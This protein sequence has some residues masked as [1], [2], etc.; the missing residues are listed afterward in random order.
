MY[1]IYSL[2]IQTFTKTL[3]Q[4][5]YISVKSGSERFE[6]CCG[7]VVNR[8]SGSRRKCIQNVWK[9]FSDPFSVFTELRGGV[10]MVSKDGVVHHMLMQRCHHSIVLMG[11][12]HFSKSFK[13]RLFSI[14]L[15]KCQFV[16]VCV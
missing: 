8:D 4:S 10:N 6:C 14:V 13:R 11:G 2:K 15:T 7:A 16:C 5:L 1:N 12:F 9:N 3:P